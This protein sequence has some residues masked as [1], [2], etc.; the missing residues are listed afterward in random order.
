MSG[1][2]QRAPWTDTGR[3]QGDI[4]RLES[5]MRSKAES[6]AV[7]SLR[8]TVDRMECALR[9]ARTETDVLR[10]Q[11]SQLEQEVEHL[12]ANVPGPF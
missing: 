6:Y 12:K 4:S 10:N 1:G 2:P 11:V 3:L 7:D 8:S 5:E 9:E